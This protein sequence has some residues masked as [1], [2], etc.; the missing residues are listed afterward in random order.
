MLNQL[1]K[2][3]DKL[4]SSLSKGIGSAANNFGSRTAQQQISQQQAAQ[5]ASMMI[6]LMSSTVVTQTMQQ[7][8]K[9]VPWIG[10]AAYESYRKS[11]HMA[12][13]QSGKRDEALIR[14]DML[15]F[16]IDAF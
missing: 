7:A 11:F 2:S 15:N 13:N 5:T 1:N 4:S 3:I 12:L 10:S 9:K 6:P 16:P 8:L 14:S